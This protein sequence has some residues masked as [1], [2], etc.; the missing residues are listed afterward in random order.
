MRI[1]HD[2]LDVGFLD[3]PT[4]TQGLSV[5]FVLGGWIDDFTDSAGHSFISR[6]FPKNRVVGFGYPDEFITPM[7][8]GDDPGKA[9]RA[10]KIGVGVINL[11]RPGG[12]RFCEEPGVVEIFPWEVEEE[13]E[14]IRFVQDVK[15]GALGYLLEKEVSLLEGEAGFVV[16]HSLENR[17]DHRPIQ[18]LWYCHPF[19]APGGMGGD[20]YVGLPATLRPSYDF[21]QPLVVDDAGRHFL[22]NDFSQLSTQLLE[23]EPADMGLFNRFEVGNRTHDRRLV[24]EG[25]FPLAFLRIWYEPRVYSPEPFYRIT[26]SPGETARWRLSHRIIESR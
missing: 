9:I 23:F 15:E 25:D 7:M 16:S 17:C 19:V 5:R 22:P 4:S 11:V 2:L 12:Y 26:L 24:V 10:V 21:I 6:E 13:G 1:T 20:C 3:I 8:I 14:R 18:T